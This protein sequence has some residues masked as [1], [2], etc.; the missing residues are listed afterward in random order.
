MSHNHLEVSV[1]KVF[2]SIFVTFFQQLSDDIL[3]KLE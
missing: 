2:V 3:L 1:K